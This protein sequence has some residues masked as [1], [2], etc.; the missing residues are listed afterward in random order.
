MYNVI[1]V[2]LKRRAREVIQIG[3]VVVLFTE[4]ITR[5]TFVTF[6]IT[7]MIYTIALTFFS[8]ISLK[9]E[10]CRDVRVEVLS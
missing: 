2:F 6:I 10:V 8:K 4:N 5:G 1:K 7:L 9:M 3:I